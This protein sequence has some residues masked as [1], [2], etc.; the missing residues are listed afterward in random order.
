MAGSRLLTTQEAAVFLKVSP[1]RVRQLVGEGVLVPEKLSI[2][3]HL[4]SLSTLKRY[5]ET[6][7]RQV[8][9]G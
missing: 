6:L 7:H 2:R 8:G 5:Q 1:A 9:D 3:A 4:F